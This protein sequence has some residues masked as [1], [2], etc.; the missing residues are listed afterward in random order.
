VIKKSD[1]E[2]LVNLKMQK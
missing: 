1:S 2:V